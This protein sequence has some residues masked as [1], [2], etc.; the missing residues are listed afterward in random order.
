ML[1]LFARH[2]IEFSSTRCHHVDR[3][4]ARHGASGGG[5]LTRTDRPNCPDCIYHSSHPPVLLKG[6]TSTKL[7]QHYDIQPLVDDPHPVIALAG[8]LMFSMGPMYYE[9]YLKLKTPHLF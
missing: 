3:W 8:D 7:K 4:Y 2:S 5:E 6:S 1:D 9:I